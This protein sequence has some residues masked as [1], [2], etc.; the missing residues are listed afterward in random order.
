MASACGALSSGVIRRVNRMRIRPEIDADRA[1]VRAVNEA[2]FETPA[3][4][5]LVEA[6][7]GKNVSLVSLVAEVDGKVVGHILLSPVSL[8]QH[9][10]PNF[11]GLAPMAVLPDYQ[12]KGIGSALVREGLGRCKDL[13]CCAV[14]VVGHAEYYPRFGFVPAGRY[15]LRCE[16]DVPANVFMVAELEA[17]ALNGVAGLVRYDDAFAGV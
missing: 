16:Y 4:A 11:M 6:L 3:E 14:V 7:H 8:T 10:Y 2:A 15:A 5:D 9:A 1:A 12:R 13:G 17:G